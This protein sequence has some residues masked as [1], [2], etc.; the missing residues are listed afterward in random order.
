MTNCPNCGAPVTS[1]KCEY[2]DTVFEEPDTV[3]LY[4][5]GEPFTTLY[6]YNNENAKLA[7]L[8]KQRLQLENALLEAKARAFHQQNCV[9]DLYKSAIEA[10]R[11]YGNSF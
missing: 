6:R 3:T 11:R 2:C 1:W 7:S 4:C 5:D 10:M 9:T 8:E